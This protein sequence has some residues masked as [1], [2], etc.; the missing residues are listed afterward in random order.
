MPCRWCCSSPVAAAGRR[1]VGRNLA[2]TAPPAAGRRTGEP[3]ALPVLRARIAAALSTLS[4]THVCRLLRAA[5]VVPMVQAAD[6]P[7]RSRFAR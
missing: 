6:H 5:R 2:G 3:R 1:R 7:Q 4:R